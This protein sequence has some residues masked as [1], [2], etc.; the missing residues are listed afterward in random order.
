MDVTL[1]MD[2]A[3]SLTA[4]L[5]SKIPLHTMKRACETPSR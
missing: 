5:S 3:E 2:Q 4:G 1:L